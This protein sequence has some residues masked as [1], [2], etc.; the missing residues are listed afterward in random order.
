[1][2]SNG[3]TSEA[4]Q[5]RLLTDERMD[6][7]IPMKIAAILENFKD[8]HVLL[9]FYAKDVWSA[10]T[11]NI[12]DDMKGGVKEVKDVK[13]TK[14]RHKQV[15]CNKCFKNMRSDSLKRHLLVHDSYGE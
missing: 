10:L 13:R 15:Q 14:D 7:R 8:R 6:E 1:M 5:V 12:V 4:D 2:S 3:G 9:C 11:D